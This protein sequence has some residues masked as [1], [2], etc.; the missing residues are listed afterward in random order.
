MTLLLLEE[1]LAGD[2]IIT[3]VIA[4]V[5]TAFGQSSSDNINLLPLDSTLSLLLLVL[6]KE[7][8]DDAD[9]ENRALIDCFIFRALPLDDRCCCLL[10]FEGDSGFD[11]ERIRAYSEPN[12]TVRRF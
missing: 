10:L 12:M 9:D 6:L 8:E 2:V 5:A 4:A 3:S 7:E 1:E 11:D